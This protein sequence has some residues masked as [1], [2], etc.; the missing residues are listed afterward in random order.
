[1][2]EEVRKVELAGVPCTI[3]LLVIEEEDRPMLRNLFEAWKELCDGLRDFRSRAVNIPEGISE[4]AFCLECGSA[5]VLK[6]QGSASFDTIDLKTLERQQ[7]KATSVKKDLTSFG[8]KSNWDTLYWLDFYKEGLFDGSFDVYRIP[9]DYIPDF[10]VSKKQ[11][12]TDQQEQERRPRLCVR[13]K[14]IIPHKIKPERTCH[15]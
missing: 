6:V 7:I 4:S 3:R 13:N 8:P 5:R 9:N 15:I 14:I 1:M 2:R 12:F 11:T 10:Q